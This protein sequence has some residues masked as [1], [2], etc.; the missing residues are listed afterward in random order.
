MQTTIKMNIGGAYF[1]IDLPAEFHT[2]YDF[3]MNSTQEDKMNI[4]RFIVEG[5]KAVHLV[6]STFPL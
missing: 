6:N 1:I 3:L 2:F 5:K 4:N